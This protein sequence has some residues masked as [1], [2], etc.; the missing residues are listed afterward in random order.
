M[1]KGGKKMEIK[2]I[3]LIFG[4]FSK[5]NQIKETLD[6]FPVKVNEDDKIK[7]NLTYFK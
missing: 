4:K 2:N 3:E 1:R 5:S 7:Y 6:K